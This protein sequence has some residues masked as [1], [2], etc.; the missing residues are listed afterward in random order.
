MNSRRF[1]VV[2]TLISTGVIG[3]ILCDASSRTA[4]GNPSLAPFEFH[5]EGAGSPEEA[6]TVL[7]YGCAAKSPRHFVQHLLLGVC[8]GPIATLQKFAECLHKTKFSHDEDVF[9][10]YDLP[11][12][13]NVKKGARV[14]AIQ[15]FDPEDKQVAALQFEMLSTYYGKHFMCADVVGEGYDGREYRTRIV[16]AQ[17]HGVWYAMPRCRSSKSFYNIADAMRLTSV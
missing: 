14:V 7:F 2:C 12:S 6:A 11:K 16:V 8:D 15:A 4:V 9:S 13:I 17:L 5:R 10:V 3:A 1:A